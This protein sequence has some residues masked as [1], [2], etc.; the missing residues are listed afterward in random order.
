MEA[1][2]GWVHRVIYIGFIQGCLGGSICGCVQG[3]IR[4]IELLYEGI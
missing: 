4:P 1:S 3:V 2:I